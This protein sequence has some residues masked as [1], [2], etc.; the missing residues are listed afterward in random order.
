MSEF[1]ITVIG[2]GVIGTSMGL[3]LKQSQKPPRL[4]VHDKELLNGQA[5]VKQKAFDK[6]EWNLVNACEQADMIILAIP[7]NGIRATLE[8]IAPYLK[9]GVT[10]TDTA[11][12]KSPVLQWAKELL[13]DH[14]HFVSGN[15]IVSA[16]GSG[17]EHATADLFQNRLYCLTPAPAT[18]EKA[19]QLIVSLVSLLEA[20]PFF[21]DA[22]EHDS[23]VTATEHL[24]AALSI[25][26]VQTLAGQ[27]AWRE[28]R[29][30]AGGLFERV[31][32]GASGDPDGMKEA[33]LNN[34]ENLTRWLD[35]YIA[36]LQQ[37]R[38]LLDEEEALVEMLDQAIVER[39]NWLI[40]YRKGR[41]KDPE[42]PSA[43]IE[44]RGFMKRLIGFGR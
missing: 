15:P 34:R 40:D 22:L 20:E 9:Q 31:S 28:A 41:F 35:L 7:L 27:T 4:L 19:I 43:Q 11:S 32:A 2:A 12:T 24:P 44:E 5:A 23:L 3:A 33:F 30:L 37:I 17:H 6:A 21:L 26:L 13:P 10:I 29:K 1:T 18:D 25:A 16:P 36:Q 14:A 38:E 8:A 42:L 39:H